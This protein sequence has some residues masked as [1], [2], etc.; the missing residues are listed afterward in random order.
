MASHISNIVI[1]AGKLHLF[2]NTDSILQ[3][4]P[5]YGDV[6]SITYFP[7][8][9]NYHVSETESTFYADYSQSVINSIIWNTIVTYKQKSYHVYIQASVL[10]DNV[11]IMSTKMV[12]WS[13]HNTPVSKPAIT[14]AEWHTYASLIYHIIGSDIYSCLFDTKS[15]YEP[16]LV[17]R[18]SGYWEDITTHSALNNRTCCG[19]CRLQSFV[20]VLMLMLV[21]NSPENGTF[22]FGKCGANK[23]RCT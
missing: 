18:Y 5:F 15:L 21:R 22:H 13:S 23:R 10:L 19:E 17:D 12:T 6:S 11:Y 4:I 14:E 3:I 1:Y 20:S 7:L 16:N 9:G 2:S 8:M